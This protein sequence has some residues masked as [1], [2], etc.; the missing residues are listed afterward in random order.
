MNLTIGVLATHPVQSFKAA[1]DGFV[2][3]KLNGNFN[4]RSYK[5]RP[6][7]GIWATAPFLHNGS[8]PSLWELLQP[9]ERRVKTFYVGSRELDPVHVGFDPA[10]SPGAC[11]YAPPSWA[12]PT[13]ATPMAR[14]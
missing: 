12:T 11:K 7:D 14:S 3:V 4:V 8:V 1:V 2:A 10:S 6:L 5:A 9:P 13:P